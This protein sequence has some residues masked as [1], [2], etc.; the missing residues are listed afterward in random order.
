MTLLRTPIRE[1]NDDIKP[2]PGRRMTEEQFLAWADEDTR[3]EWVD[4]KVEMMSPVSREHDM[5][6]FWL[7]TV[8]QYY[9]EAKKLGD[10]H[11]SEFLSRL[12]DQFRMPDVLFVRASRASIV[13]PT[14]VDGPPDLIVEVVSPDEPARDYKDKYAAY[15]S[16]GVRE[17]WI[18]DPA[19]KQIQA[20][21]LSRAKKF[22]PME[23]ADDGFHSKVL[24]GL[25][26]KSQWLF[27]KPR[28]SALR[29]LK[30]L[31]VSTPSDL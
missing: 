31:G 27:S 3:A 21:M 26:I 16:A 6:G 11:G 24:P 30:E 12:P 20:Y 5:L 14:Y 22:R 29:I 28:P 23:E 7:R 1:S 15:Q 10:V 4:G 8:I 13:G 25:R 9:S 17:Y 19:K 18:V 2:H